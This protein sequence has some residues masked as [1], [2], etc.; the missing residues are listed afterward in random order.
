MKEDKK[1]FEGKTAI[2]TGA[3]SGIGLAL[4]EELLAYGAKKVVIA[5]FNKENLETHTSR[6]SSQY[7]GKVKG[8]LCNVTC[9]DEVKAMIAG[10]VEFFGGRLDL[11]I[12]NAG[13]GFAGFFTAPSGQNVLQEQGMRRNQDFLLQVSSPEGLK[14][15]VIF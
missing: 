13:A 14:Q 10:A 3:A 7:P 2:V 15:A 6:L 9:E 11:L 12:N 4:I 1:Y 5:D 8:I